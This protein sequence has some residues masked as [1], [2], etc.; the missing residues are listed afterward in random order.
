MTLFGFTVIR[1]QILRAALSEA[2][3]LAL[4]VRAESE[5]RIKADKTGSS[6]G[7]SGDFPRSG[8]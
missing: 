7:Y 5:A 1:E 3:R 2:D 8:G 6:H 4:E